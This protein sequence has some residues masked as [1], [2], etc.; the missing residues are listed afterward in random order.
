MHS[1]EAT[2]K[3]CTQSDKQIMKK[4]MMTDSDES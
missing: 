2:V 1:V 3:I 4:Q